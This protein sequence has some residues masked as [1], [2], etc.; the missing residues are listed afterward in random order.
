MRSRVQSR[1]IGKIVAVSV[2]LFGLPLSTFSTQAV[3]DAPNEVT[4]TMDPVKTSI[5]WT[6]PDVLHIVHGRFTLKN[7]IIHLNPATGIT[8][9][10]IAVMLERKKRE[11]S[12]R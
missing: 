3:R 2:G 1:H 9:G 12:P 4:I 10:L 5:Q 6:L 8:D 11:R 7:G